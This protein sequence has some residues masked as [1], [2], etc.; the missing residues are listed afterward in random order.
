MV[1]WQFKANQSAHAQRLEDFILLHE[2]GETKRCE[3]LYQRLNQELPHLDD[4][5]LVDDLQRSSMVVDPKTPKPESL[6]WKFHVSTRN[7]LHKRSEKR[8]ARLRE[9]AERP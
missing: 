7:E 9:Q 4:K 2:R 6:T 1:L 3:R 8:L 5:A